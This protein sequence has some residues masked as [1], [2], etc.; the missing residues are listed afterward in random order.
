MTMSHFFIAASLDADDYRM[1]RKLYNDECEFGCFYRRRLR[2]VFAD[3][4]F[5][6]GAFGVELA[7]LAFDVERSG[8]GVAFDLAAESQY[9]AGLGMEHNVMRIDAAFET[10]GLI[11]PFEMA[12]YLVAIL[13]QVDGLGIQVAVP[14]FRLD[15]PMPG[16]IHWRLLVWKWLLRCGGTGKKKKRK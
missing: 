2:E 1:L 9:S 8:H 5:R 7:L 12:G 13:L 16:H 11:R 4:L 10:S 3:T 6:S 14:V 15:H